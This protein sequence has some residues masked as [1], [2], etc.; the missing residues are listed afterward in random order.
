MF[1]LGIAANETLMH[2]RRHW[3]RTVRW[4]AQEIQR[5]F[6][7]LSTLPPTNVEVD[8]GVAEDGFFV[9]RPRKNAHA[10]VTSN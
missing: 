5:D 10:A 2:L 3:P 8:I 9:W 1:F 6:V 4:S 7:P